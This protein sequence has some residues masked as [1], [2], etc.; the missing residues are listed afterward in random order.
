MI[1]RRSVGLCS[2]ILVML[3]CQLRALT[4]DEAARYVGKQGAVNGIAVQVS[5][6]GGHVF[7]NFGAK[8][9]DQVFTAFVARPDVPAVG[10]AYLKSLEGRPVSVV[11]RIGKS[12]GKP[13]IQVTKRD[14]IILAVEIAP[15]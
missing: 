15:R 4:P 12:K 3:V 9:P 1:L 8:Y 2:A 7:V 13:Q 14:Q 5:Q 6:A 11:G 10:W